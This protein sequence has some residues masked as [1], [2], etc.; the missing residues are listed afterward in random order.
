MPVIPTP[1]TLPS[2]SQSAPMTLWG[3]GAVPY[4]HLTK[5]E[6]IC[7]WFTDDSTQ[8]AGTT[9]QCAIIAP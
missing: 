6:K 3:G 1:V 2:L 8:H 4:D 9:Q 7:A 5:E